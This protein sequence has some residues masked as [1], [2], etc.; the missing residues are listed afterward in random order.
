MITLAAVALAIGLS[1]FTTMAVKDRTYVASPAYSPVGEAGREAAV[2]YY[3]RSGHTEA[4]AREIARKLNAPIA[5][6]D[7]DYA[8]GF[9]GQG[10]AM[11]DATSGALPPIQIE[12]IDLRP[13]RRVYLVS[14]T[15][16]FRPAPPLWSYINQTNLSGKEVV[17]VMTGNSRFKQD[18][19]DA[20]S[21]LIDAQGGRLIHHIFLRRGRIY[22]QQSRTQLLEEIDARMDAIIN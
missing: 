8:L 16:M 15:W 11:S 14:P 21:S 20:F 4:V 10:K 13:A 22:W 12:P 18:E 6:I 5:R 1:A 7:A 2:I 19:I 3:S 9:Q 17:L